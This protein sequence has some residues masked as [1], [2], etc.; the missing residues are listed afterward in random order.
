MAATQPL[1]NP[2][3]VGIIKTVKTSPPSVIIIPQLGG[4]LVTAT[5]FTP[6]QLS[7]M[8]MCLSVDMRQVTYTMKLHP[9]GWQAQEVLCVGEVSSVLKEEPDDIWLR[10]ARV[11]GK[12]SKGGRRKGNVYVGINL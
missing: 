1:F 9:T 10:S 8:L 7:T 3:Y 6:A 11:D 12:K 4:P 5:D 2:R